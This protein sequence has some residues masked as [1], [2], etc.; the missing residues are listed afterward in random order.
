MV[1][2][3]DAQTEGA[4]L[5][6]KTGVLSETPA[7]DARLSAKENL[8]IFAQ[9]FGVPKVEI[10]KPVGKVLEQFHLSERANEWQ[11]ILRALRF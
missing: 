7:L 4:E 5:R 8:A 6:R 9:L 3:H 1:L 11:G 2:G 10:G